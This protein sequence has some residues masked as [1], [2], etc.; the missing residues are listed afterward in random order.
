M[1]TPVAFSLLDNQPDWTEVAL[2][3][4]IAFVF[5]S[6]VATVL[7]RLVRSLLKAIYGETAQASPRLI[8]RPVFVTRLIAFL[9]TFFVSV[10]PLLDAIG[11]RLD[12]GLTP[13]EA[14]VEAHGG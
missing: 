8:R 2:V 5:A 9:L 4:G 12:F 1:T 10:V 11:E 13:P 6:I 7:A 3:I 14:E